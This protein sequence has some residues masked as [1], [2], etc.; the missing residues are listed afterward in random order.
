MMPDNSRNIYKLYRGLALIILN[1]IVILVLINIALGIYFSHKDSPVNHKFYSSGVVVT[2]SGYFYKNG[3]PVDNGK[4]RLSVMG[5]FDYLPFED[6]MTEAEISQLLDEDHN[7]SRLEMPYRAWVQYSAPQ[8]NGTYINVD[9][10]DMGFSVRNTPPNPQYSDSEQPVQILALGGSTTF[11]LKVADY[12]TYP[13]YL[14]EILNRRAEKDNLDVGV[15]VLNYGRRG[16]YIT[17]EMYLLLDILRGGKRPELVIFLDG[18]NVGRDDDTPNYTH[19]ISRKVKD[20]QVGSSLESSV[21]WKEVPLL[22]AVRS[23]SARLRGSSKQQLEPVVKHDV[24][25]VVERFIQ[26][27]ESIL[28]ICQQYGIE[29]MFILQPDAAYNYPLNLYRNPDILN[30][31]GRKWREAFYSDMKQQPGFIDFTHLFEEWGRKAIIDSA[32]YSPPFNQF[33]AK[34]IA[35]KIDLLKLKQNRTLPGRPTYS[36]RRYH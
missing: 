32:H 13:A 35:S 1:I 34:N 6:T 3:A 22:R 2:D 36:K 4:R 25:T 15:E 8:F 20:M 18:L 5:N 21:M 17:Q 19:R 27:R 14:E 31:N 11:G 29:C 33:L 9:L 12:H 23:L 24:S 10:D 16:F 30:M 26:S 7:F 28:N